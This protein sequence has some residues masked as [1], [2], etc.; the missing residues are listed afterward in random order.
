MTHQNSN[1]IS[2]RTL[3]RTGTV[4][5][6]TMAFA[7]SILRADGHRVRKNMMHEGGKKD[8]D[9][10]R[11][12][13]G[14]M[15]DL[16]LD[17]PRNWYRNA[18]VHF[19]DCPHGNWWFTS[20][21][22]GYLGYFEEIIREVTGEEDFML[23]YW[24]WTKNNYVPPSMFGADNALDPVNYAPATG[25]YIK[26]LAEFKATVREPMLE[27]WNALT[28]DQRAEQDKRKNFDFEIMWATKHE[29][30]AV[31]SFQEQKHARFLTA[32]NPDLDANTQPLVAL[33]NVLGDLA[34][35]EFS[36]DFKSKRS[37]YFENSVTGSHHDPGHF[38]GLSNTHNLVHNC[39]GGSFD[40]DDNYVAPYGIMTQNLSPLDPI[41][42]L[43]HGNIDRLWDVWTRKQIARGHSIQPGPKEIEAYK[44]E[45]YLFFVDRHGDP[46]TD[47]TTSWDFF[48]M[49]SFDYI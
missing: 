32:E 18:F 12:A 46:V 11:K 25:G 4:A 16:P 15:L 22:R 21:H 33:D 27:Y 35:T 37:P 41:F 24:D 30:N 2:R 1:G 39:T 14:I 17:D 5:A 45:P 40:K 44:N 43:H 6:G 48:S 29:D 19:I 26:T 47:R 20:W 42:F 7:P 10:Y 9:T 13:V 3:L 8:L 31:D 38:S 49:E 34:P 28:P 36:G 23:P